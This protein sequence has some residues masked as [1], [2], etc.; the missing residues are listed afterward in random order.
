MLLT[1]DSAV[2]FDSGSYTLKESARKELQKLVEKI[3]AFPSG[4]ITINGHTDNVGKPSSNLQLSENRA[5]SVA[6]VIQNLLGDNYQYQI[7]GYGDQQPIAPNN[8]PENKQ[9]NRRV[10]LLVTPTIQ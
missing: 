2:L 7:H 9:K 10:E 3:K 8:T 5:V 1:L 4:T 6:S